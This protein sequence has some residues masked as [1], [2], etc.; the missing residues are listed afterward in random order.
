MGIELVGGDSKRLSSISGMGVMYAWLRRGEC[1]DE[2]WG[3]NEGI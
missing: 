2:E 3:K 1:G